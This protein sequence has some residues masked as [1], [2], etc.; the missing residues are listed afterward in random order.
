MDSLTQLLDFGLMSNDSKNTFSILQKVPMR[1][2]KSKTSWP[3]PKS[4]VGKFC[5]K[6]KGKYKCW[7]AKGPAQ[8]A[9]EEISIEIRELL[10]R[11]CGPVPSSEFVHF[12]MFMIGEKP[13]TAIPHIMFACKKLGPRKE[14]LTTILK[15]DILSRYTSGIELGHWDYPPYIKDLQFLG[16][17]TETA[18]FGGE[19]TDMFHCHL[20]PVFDER[21]PRLVSVMRLQVSSSQHD[22]KPP[23]KATVGSIFEIAGKRFYLAP[24]H[25]FSERSSSQRVTLDDDIE[26]GDSDCEFGG[27]D[28]ENEDGSEEDEEDEVEFVHYSIAP[29]SNDAVSESEFDDSAY[30]S[31]AGS[32]DLP[33]VEP[34][35]ELKFVMSHYMSRLPSLNVE[36]AGQAHTVCHEISPFFKSPE[37]DCALIEV[38]KHDYYLTTGLPSLSR[39][40]VYF[41]PGNINV[42]TSTGSR[43]A[44]TG[45]LCGKPLFI[46]F[47]HARRYQKAF[48]VQFEKGLQPGDCGA[49]V[50]NEQA[51]YGHIFAGSIRSN[52]A[53]IIPTKEVLEAV[54]SSVAKGR[55]TT[56]E[57]LSDR[58]GNNLHANTGTL[59]YEDF[60]V[61]W[62]CSLSQV[63]EA[64]RDM[65]DE[66]YSTLSVLDSDT[67]VLG[68]I[69]QHNV[70]LADPLSE[71]LYRKSTS[72]VALKMI[73][74]FF[75]IR[76]IISTGVGT[77]PSTSSRHLR[78]GDVVVGTPDGSHNGVVQFNAQI[79]GQKDYMFNAPPKTLLTAVSRLQATHAE[80]NEKL[81]PFFPRASSNCALVEAQ[82][83]HPAAETKQPV[84]EDQH[85]E[86]LTGDCDH[87]PKIHYGLIA[88]GYTGYG[89]AEDVSCFDWHT[90]TVLKGFPCLYVRAMSPASNL[91]PRET[92][93]R[94]KYADATA[95]AYVRELL[96]TLS[97][98]EVRRMLPAWEAINAKQ[99]EALQTLDKAEDHKEE[100]RKEGLRTLD[101]G[102]NR[103]EPLKKQDKDIDFGVQ[104]S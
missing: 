73:S 14:A 20:I 38:N 55:R 60:T 25:I 104:T 33:T 10:E 82:T 91:T 59:T 65:L 63:F 29:E 90:R 52:V 100:L 87:V 45:I 78:V 83:K 47:P 95:S 66:E 77:S 102:G 71:A 6:K 61:G 54:E 76:F 41:G 32:E 92:K 9:F 17:S 74:T 48:A 75:N 103:K 101:K 80:G 69:G 81:L 51:V 22:F 72:T 68:K 37:L 44:L 27:F 18:N 28:N 24:A 89:N 96:L 88:V 40:D 30:S 49:I 86:C 50:Q 3:D 15:S 19:S 21:V 97:V 46:R 84:E 99:L 13:S 8:E 56:N 57:G 5:G 79:K 94:E 26:E 39:G 93:E 62:I 36:A 2:K 16:S 58:P 34:R 43:R 12:E 98:R 35:K 23:C 70:V 11:D 42:R 4:S 67:Y 1:P 31:D 85:N 64:A 53:Y 7:R